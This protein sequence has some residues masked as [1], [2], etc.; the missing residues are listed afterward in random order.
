MGDNQ[1]NAIRFVV[2]VVRSNSVLRCETCCQLPYNHQVRPVNDQGCE[3]RSS[4]T[5]FAYI[6]HWFTTVSDDLT[7]IQGTA[8]PVIRYARTIIDALTTS[9]G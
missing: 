3:S 6:G 2:S 4:E 7:I 1:P 8:E 9:D 5:S